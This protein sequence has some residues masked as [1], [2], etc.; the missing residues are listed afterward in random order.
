[1]LFTGRFDTFQT[2]FLFYLYDCRLTIGL[3]INTM[4]AGDFGN[5]NVELVKSVSELDIPKAAILGNH[6]A[7]NTREFSTE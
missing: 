6:D 1:M 5:E 2:S 4:V 3:K 7:W